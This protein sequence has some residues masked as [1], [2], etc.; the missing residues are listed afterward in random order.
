MA[1][2]HGLHWQGGGKGGGIHEG[3][4]QLG[5]PRLLTA[6][7]CVIKIM[8]IVCSDDQHVGRERLPWSTVKSIRT[9]SSGYWNDRYIGLFDHIVVTMEAGVAS[10]EANPKAIMATECAAEL[11]NWSKGSRAFIGPLVCQ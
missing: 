7:L 5:A 4:K 3:F 8:S 11:L 6:L 10:P 2:N 9:I 1:P